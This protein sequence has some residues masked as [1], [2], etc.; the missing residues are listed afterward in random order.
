MIVAQEKLGEA[1]GKYQEAKEAQETEIAA[2]REGQKAR[3][4]DEDAAAEKRAEEEREEER[5]R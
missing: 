2:I 3:T 4:A 5:K 1:Q